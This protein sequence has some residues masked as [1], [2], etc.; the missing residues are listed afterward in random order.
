[1]S[2]CEG[3]FISQKEQQQRLESTKLLAKD[4]AIKNNTAVAI[5][6]EG[7]DYYYCPAGDA[8]ERSLPI[9]SIVPAH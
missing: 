7:Y 4:Y 2:G 9:V 6:K 5:Y 1:M 8:I 3:C